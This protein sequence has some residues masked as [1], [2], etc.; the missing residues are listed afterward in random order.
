MDPDACFSELLLALAEG[1]LLTAGERA[2]DLRN[3]IVAGGFYPGGGKIRQAA[4]DAFITWAIERTGKG[5]SAPG[6]KRRA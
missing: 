3:W 5:P 6:R 4:I 2:E 1:D